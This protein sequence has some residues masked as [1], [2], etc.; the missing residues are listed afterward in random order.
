M[1]LAMDPKQMFKVVLRTDEDKPVESQ[2]RFIFQFLTGRE[3]KALAR[4]REGFNELPTGPAGFDVVCDAVRVGLCGWENI[5]DRQ[6]GEM[7]PYNPAELDSVIT[8]SESLE[9]FFLL[10]SRA[11]MDSSDKKKLDLP[12]ASS[13]AESVKDVEELQSAK[14]DQQK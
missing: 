4:L 6:T 3:W 5:T 13:T 14:T 2:P 11:T 1:P 8:F 12:L 10:L 9:L 7:I